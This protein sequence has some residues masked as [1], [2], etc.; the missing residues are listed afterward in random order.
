MG[1]RRRGKLRA[2]AHR[3]WDRAGFTL[4]EILAVLLI[5]GLLMSIM[6]PNFG[7]VQT[8]K[9]RNSAEQIVERIDFGR[10]RAVMTG[11]PHRLSIDLDTG[12]YQLK[13]QGDR[14]VEMKKP[15]KP[16]LE[17]EFEPDA[18]TQLSLAPPPSTERS[19]ETLQ[20]PL[21]KLETL[22]RGVE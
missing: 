20:G 8:H 3:A 17:F 18:E 12:T 6:L 7:A 4:L 14:P 22:G 21:G 1:R 10:Q 16:D 15:A 2:D 5:G 9:L 13:W 19:C 11:V